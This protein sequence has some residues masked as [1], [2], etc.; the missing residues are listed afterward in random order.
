MTVAS[1][2]AMRVLV[3]ISEKDRNSVQLGLPARI[4][5]EAYPGRIFEGQVVGLRSGSENGAANTLADIHVANPKH[6]LKTAMRASVSLAVG[7]KPNVL[8]VPRQAVTEIA[9]KSY[10]DVVAGGRAQRR[11]I[12]VGRNQDTTVEVTSGV[13]E[14][15]WVIVGGRQPRTTDGRVRIVAETTNP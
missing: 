6:L 10:V 11:A 4:T 9:G 7:E 14:G 5:V 8:L 2:D 3:Q 12:T 1:L 15:D 13:R